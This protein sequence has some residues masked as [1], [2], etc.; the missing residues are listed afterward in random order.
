[1]I[2]IS[3][4]ANS[5]II[6][7]QSGQ[8]GYIVSTFD[9]FQFELSPLTQF[10]TNGNDTMTALSGGTISAPS[11]TYGLDG[12]DKITGST[13]VDVIY[14]GAGKDVLQGVGGH[15]KLD[16]G[17]GND[18]IWGGGDGDI[19]KGGAGDDYLAG[20]LSAKN[21]I[22]EGG[23]GNDSLVGSY[24]GG[25]IIDGGI[26]NDF[27]MIRATGSGGADNRYIGG[28]GWDVASLDRLLVAPNQEAW[29]DVNAQGDHVLHWMARNGQMQTDIVEGIEQFNIAGTL[30]TFDQLL[31]G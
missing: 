31:I 7:Q 19:L 8:A 13:G 29:I 10:G 5:P 6:A 4:I 3:S 11:I 1:M 17:T 12:D 15:D 9:A 30:Y 16:G 21:V 26:G 28:S 22:L 27:F 24:G 23:A 20:A 18:T 25:G 14:G 2:T